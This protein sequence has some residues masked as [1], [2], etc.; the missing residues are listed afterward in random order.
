MDRYGNGLEHSLK[1]NREAGEVGSFIVSEG[2]GSIFKDKRLN[3]TGKII[4][5]RRYHK[6]WITKDRQEKNP[7]VGEFEKTV[8]D[9]KE[10]KVRA[11]RRF[12]EEIDP[13]LGY[14]FSIYVVPSSDPLARNRGVSILG[15]MLAR[16]GRK[17]VI[18][19]K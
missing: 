18:R 15:R 17:E 13:L 16:N 5:L 12:F 14:G 6:Y 7:L 1:R 8:L 9:L 19:Q 4:A 2:S 10:M 3:G 11:I